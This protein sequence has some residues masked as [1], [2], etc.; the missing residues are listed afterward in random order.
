MANEVLVNDISGGQRYP[1]LYEG[2]LLLELLDEEKGIPITAAFW[3]LDSEN[4]TWRYILAS[5]IVD[6][7]GPLEAYKILYKIFQIYNK[8]AEWW[9][10]EKVRS[11]AEWWPYKKVRSHAEWWP[12]KKV[13]SHAEWWPYK[14]VRS[15]KE[16]AGLGIGLTLQDITLVSPDEPVVK[17][18]RT[19]VKTP[20]ISTSPIHFAGNS[21]NNMFIADA[22]IYRMLPKSS[23]DHPQSDVL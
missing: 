19:V 23:R 14:K 6:T 18:L 15:Y 17:L 7:Q 2:K 22:Y 16:E 11:H 9:P 21:I 5:P 3:L 8:E 10:Y 4:R 1:L 20:P 13:R 12:Y